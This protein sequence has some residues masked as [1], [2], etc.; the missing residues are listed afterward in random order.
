[1][2]RYYVI[3]WMFM[4][5]LNDVR[6]LTEEVSKLLTENE[7]LERI[8]LHCCDKTIMVNFDLKYQLFTVLFI[9]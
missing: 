9:G 7:D 2:G 4:A 6:K 3:L 8:E 1:M 5:F